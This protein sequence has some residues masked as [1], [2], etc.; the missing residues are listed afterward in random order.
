[1]KHQDLVEWPFISKINPNS[2]VDWNKPSVFNEKVEDEI[3]ENRKIKP[4]KPQNFEYYLNNLLI[5][6]PI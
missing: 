1:M 2:V 4:V 3:H 6:N 5:N